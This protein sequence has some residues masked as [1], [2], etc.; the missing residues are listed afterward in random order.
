MIDTGSKDKKKKIKLLKIIGGSCVGACLLLYACSDSDKQ[1]ESN[2]SVT[3]KADN[4]GSPTES[5]NADFIKKVQEKNASDAEKAMEQGDSHIDVGTNKVTEDVNEKDFTGEAASNVAASNTV[6]TSD[7][8]SNTAASDVGKQVEVR[9][10]I[11]TEVKY[12]PLEEKYNYLEDVTLL[13]LFDKKHT[14]E[15]AFKVTKVSDLEK[16]EQIAK[17]Q[18]AKQE[19]K[20]TA[21][22]SNANG[23]NQTADVNND[24]ISVNKVGDLI[25]AT[26]Q[27]GLDSRNPSIVRAVIE[28]GPFAGS[29]LTGTFQRTE[30]ALSVNFT[31]LNSPMLKE[32]LAINT[33]A[34]NY[35]NAATALADYVNRHIPERVIWTLV[36]SFANGFADALKDNNQSS[37]SRTMIDE[38]TG[39]ATTINESYRTKKTNKELMKEAGATG[40][41]KAT[42]LYGNLVPK[43][44]T[45]KVNANSAIGIYVLNDIKV[46]KSMFKNP[47]DFKQFE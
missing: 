2:V 6:D 24:G 35:D 11:V 14:K 27:S 43:E 44:A 13:D 38:N 37:T 46:T 29:I 34:M 19:A 39:K 33:V 28:T 10:K 32:T 20:Q 31:S 8:N 7:V 12:V 9:E 3:Q 25:P 18:E 1:E 47:E 41:S 42:E 16:R 22:A 17:E 40:I 21:Q 15:K 30:T 26:L 45:V 36:S 4:T 5:T 23:G